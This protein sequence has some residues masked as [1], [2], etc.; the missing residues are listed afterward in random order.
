VNFD[1]YEKKHFATYA[2]F[3][4]TVRFILEK[5]LEAS[6][7]LPAPQSIQSRAKQPA[8]LRA[9]LIEA[10]NLETETL[11][12]DRRDLAGARLIFYTNNDVERFLSSQLINDNFEVERE[13]IKIHHPTEENAR[14]RYRARHYTVRLRA[15]RLA[16]PEY[17]KFAGLRCEIQIQTILN[18]AR[19]ETSHDILYKEKLA[20]GFGSKAMRGIAKRFENIM[21]KYLIP[22]GYEIQKAQ[23]EYERLQQGK[24]LF[25]GDVAKLLDSVENNND[26]YQILSGLKD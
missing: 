15:D 3:A 13:S 7:G 17:A 18:H 25:D 21:D 24:E 5:A 14:A 6:A 12:R 4:Q 23:Q 11:E 22:A 1:D 10:G 19:S 8:S 2:V 9:R 26:R 16:L 20:E